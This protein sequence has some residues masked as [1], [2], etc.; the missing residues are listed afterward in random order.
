MRCWCRD[1]G[2]ARTSLSLAEAQDGHSIRVRHGARLIDVEVAK[3]CQ[4]I[5]R[6]RVAAVTGSVDFNHFIDIPTQVVPASSFDPTA[7]EDMVLEFRLGP[8]SR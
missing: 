6:Y 4:G 5:A 8:P 7:P 3:Q 2:S 1:V